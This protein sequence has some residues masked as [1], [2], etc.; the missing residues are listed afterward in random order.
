MKATGL[1]NKFRKTTGSGKMD[2]IGWKTTDLT[3]SNA[4]ANL[5]KNCHYGLVRQSK[6]KLWSKK[7]F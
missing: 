7:F 1:T 5:K 2:A 3:D 6:V 4:S